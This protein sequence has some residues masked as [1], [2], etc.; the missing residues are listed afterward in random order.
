MEYSPQ[1]PS[2]YVRQLKKELGLRLGHN[3]YHINTGIE[4]IQKV[5]KLKQDSSFEKIP[6]LV[7]RIARIQKNMP[8]CENQHELQ[9]PP[10]ILTLD[11]RRAFVEQEIGNEPRV[12]QMTDEQ[13]RTH[14]CLMDEEMDCEIFHDHNIKK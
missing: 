14:R 4:F 7:K 6:E 2:S 11:V 1:Q 9:C 5:L 3:Q 13:N 8:R 12:K 10:E